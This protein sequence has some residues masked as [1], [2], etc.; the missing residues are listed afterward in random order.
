MT[1]T[2]AVKARRLLP[3]G[4]LMVKIVDPDGQF[5]WAQCRGDSGEVYDLGYDPKANQWRCT[6]AELKG[7]C[8]HLQA[9]KLVVVL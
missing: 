7:N 4:R 1:E 6:C 3:E 8:S 9:L 5:V 2:A